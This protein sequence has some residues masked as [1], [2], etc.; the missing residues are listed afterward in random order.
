MKTVGVNGLHFSCVDEGSGPAIV[1]LHGFPL[2]KSMWCSQIDEFS[3]THRVIAPDLRGHGESPVTKGAVTMAE[4]AD[5]VAGILDALEVANA[6]V[7]GLSMGGYV[8]WEFWRRHKDKLAALVLCDTRAVADTAEVA[9][10]REM[11]AAQVATTGSKMA[12]DSMV[13]KL[14]GSAT[15][16]NNPKA[17][18]WLRETILATDPEGIAATQRGMAKRVDVTQILSKVDVPT[19]VLC[20]E[21]DSI[22]PPDEMTGFASAMPNAQFIEIPQAGHLAPLEQ[23]A[24]TNEAIRNFLANL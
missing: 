6:I 2:S 8:A 4:M 7:C 22:S 12:A 3:K 18:E 11:M 16:D 20:G 5:D 14:F 15:Y 13:P 24:A 23:P 10:G 9:R 1:L 21:E 17:V 19:L